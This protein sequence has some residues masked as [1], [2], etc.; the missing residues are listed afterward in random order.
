MLRVIA[1]GNEL[2]L[3][4]PPRPT[5]PKAA[6]EPVWAAKLRVK[7]MATVMLGMPAMAPSDRVPKAR[8]SGPPQGEEK[9]D[10]LA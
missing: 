1:Y 3:V 9:A 5:D 8:P 7:S 10:A 2:N 4:H 6:W